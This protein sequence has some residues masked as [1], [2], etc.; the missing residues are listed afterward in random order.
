MAEKKDATKKPNVDEYHT[1]VQ[2]KFRD[3]LTEL[4]RHSEYMIPPDKIPK[5]EKVIEA[6][7]QKRVAFIKT[8]F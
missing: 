8:E 5:I 6:V 7:K 3:L 2:E 1:N 4:N